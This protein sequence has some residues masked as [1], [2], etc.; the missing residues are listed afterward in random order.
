MDVRKPAWLNHNPS[1]IILPL[2]CGLLAAVAFILALAWTVPGP[3]QGR[4]L[5]IVAG[6][7]AA[8]MLIAISLMIAGGI[9]EREPETPES[10]ESQFGTG[11]AFITSMTGLPLIQLAMG[12]LGSIL[13]PRAPM[14]VR[15]IV[16]IAVGLV[17]GGLL[18]LVVAMAVV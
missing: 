4:R 9:L 17:A 5:G 16:A 7:A 13:L 12:L 2:F 15:V 8:V 14:A 3:S 11:W 10:Q 1:M 18:W 6:S